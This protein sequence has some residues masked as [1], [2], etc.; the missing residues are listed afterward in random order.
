MPTYRLMQPHSPKPDIVGAPPV[1]PPYHRIINHNF[2]RVTKE[3]W[4]IHSP[5]ASW[6]SHFRYRVF[7]RLLMPKSHVLDQCSTSLGIG[8]VLHVHTD[9][10]K[11]LKAS[12]PLH[13][14]R[15][16]CCD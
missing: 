13:G 15:H 9:T 10:E 12:D 8:A 14:C 11:Q 2:I 5:S 3:H 16:G 7:Y 1:L 4:Q 6:P